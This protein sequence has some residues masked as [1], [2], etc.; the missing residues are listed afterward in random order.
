VILTFDDASSS[1]FRWDEQSAGIRAIDPNTAMGVLEGFFQAHPDFG[2]GGQFAVLPFNCFADG[3]PLNTIEDCPDKLRWMAANGYEIVNHTAGHQDML[4]ITDEEFKFQIGDPIIW[5]NG[6][7]QGDAN[8]MDV[9]VMPFGNYPSKDLH[10]EQREMMRNGFTYEGHEIQVKAAFMVGANPTESPSST[11]YDPIFIARIQA[12]E[13][14]LDQWFGWLEDG[15][16]IPYVSDGDP[17]TVT[18][19]DPVPD[20]LA[21]QFD[22]DFIV[23]DGH[24]LVQYDP[25]TGESPAGSPVASG[26]D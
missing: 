4:D 2:R 24:T 26:R 10:P 7:I 20:S 13:A 12:F 23:A 16:T 3:T 11:A 17:L 8:M 14:S 22:P 15:N 5:L 25:E 18:I 1:Q 6:I 9:V 19:P 21:G